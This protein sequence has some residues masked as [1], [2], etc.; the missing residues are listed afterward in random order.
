MKKIIIS[1]L[2]L[3]L[4]VFTSC[5][6]LLNEN[7]KDFASPEGFFNTE[8]EVLSALYGVYGYLHDVYIGDYERILLGD[9]GVDVM[10]CRQIPRIDIYQH[11]QMEA[12]TVEF[13]TSW[14]AHYSAIGAANMVIARTEKSTLKEDF[15]QLVISEARFLRAYFYHNLVL[16]WGDVPMWLGEL[17]IEDVSIL[18]RAPKEQVIDQI[19]DDLEFASSHLPENRESKDLGRITSWGA[20]SLIARVSLLNN[21]WQKAYESSKE[22]ILSSPHKLLGQYKEVFDYKNKFNDELIFVIPCLA[23]V[24][25]SLIHSFSNP[26]ARDESNKVN[27]AFAEG[28]GAI[29]P[30][31]VIVSSAGSLFQGWGMFNSSENLLRSFQIGDTRKELMD[32]SGLELTDGSFVSF[33]GG[34]GGGS[35]HYSLKWIAFDEKANNGSR[36]IHQ[37]RLAELYL[38][39]AEAANE[40]NKPAEAIEALNALRMRA[41]MDEKANYALTLSKE[42]IKKAIVNENKWELCGEGLRRWYLVHWGYE[43]LLNAVQAL[44]EENPQAVANIKP[45]HV[46]FKIPEEEFVKNPNLGSNNP[47]Y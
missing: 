47:G 38:I 35:G 33:D 22:V 41:F 11:Y 18:S 28:I 17:N 15:K 44:E 9:L 14:K 21:Q 46:L 32:W 25:G 8:D 1:N 24:K 5:S 27:A 3:L 43:Y 29:R 40:L 42:E 2:I 12:P 30:D 10:V 37:I 16:T 34:D 31:G 19:L 4:L 36:D 20:K 45:H 26:R 13:S 23:D 6:N 7:P 39:L